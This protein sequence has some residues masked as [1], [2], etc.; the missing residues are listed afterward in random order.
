MKPK[1]FKLKGNQLSP[2]PDIMNKGLTAIGSI[3]SFMRFELQKKIAHAT[4]SGKELFDCFSVNKQDVLILVRGAADKEHIE[5]GFYSDDE[6][7]GTLHVR[8]TRKRMEVQENLETLP[9]N[10]EGLLCEIRNYK[11]YNLEDLELVILPDFKDICTPLRDYIQYEA[12]KEDIDIADPRNKHFVHDRNRRDFRRL[13][14]FSAEHDINIITGGDLAQSGKSFYY[15]PEFSYCDT[16]LF[17]KAGRKF[18][19]APPDDENF[20]LEIVGKNIRGRNYPLVYNGF[21]G[22][23]FSQ[24]QREKMKNQKLLPNERNIIDTLWETD[25]GIGPTELA[26]KTSIPKSTVIQRCEYLGKPFKGEWVIKKGT[27]YF[28]NKKKLR[29]WVKEQGPIASTLLC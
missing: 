28:A 9:F 5:Q 26:N 12:G 24:E 14:D 21:L 22:F 7:I 17:L 3:E 2:I 10:Y 6:R 27:K 18:K 19:S 1:K 20:I 15:T 23:H 11:S 29:A 16:R 4:A 25:E 8:Q 13:K